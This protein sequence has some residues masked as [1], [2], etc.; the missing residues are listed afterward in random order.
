MNH[1]QFTLIATDND[2]RK[3]ITKIQLTTKQAM[4]AKVDLWDQKKIYQDL[5]KKDFHKTF[6]KNNGNMMKGKVHK[7]TCVALSLRTAYA[8]PTVF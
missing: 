1:S 6:L 5:K 2:D 4:M 8:T 3:N 7:L